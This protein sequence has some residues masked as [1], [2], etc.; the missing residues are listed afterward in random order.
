[1]GASNASAPPSTHPL[2][3]VRASAPPQAGSSTTVRV[4]APPQTGSSTAVRASAPPQAGSSTTV[5]ASAP[6]QT[7]PST[8]AHTSQTLGPPFE[9][10]ILAAAHN[11]TLRNR[12][13]IANARS[14]C[15][16]VKTFAV[17]E[18]VT[19]LIPRDDRLK[20]DDKRCFAKVFDVVGNPSRYR[21]QTQYGILNNR[22]LTK[23]LMPVTD[24]VAGYQEVGNNPTEITI[25]K[26][27]H[28]AS[29]GKGGRICEDTLQ[30]S[31]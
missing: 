27:G 13:R 25:H 7:D 12:K 17:D 14:P 24:G 20:S 28:L 5:R 8:T 4:S 30:V 6:P 10:P 2:A 18:L 29:G 1:M 31:R 16:P 26:L 11:Q 23:H 9:D 22:P 15:H 19:F 3:T 21:L